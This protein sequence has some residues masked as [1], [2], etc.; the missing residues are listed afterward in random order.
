MQTSQLA[1]PLL[2]RVGFDNTDG[3]QSQGTVALVHTQLA[4]TLAAIVTPR[5][6]S[7]PRLLATAHRLLVTDGVKT[8]TAVEIQRVGKTVPRRAHPLQNRCHVDWNRAAL[9]TT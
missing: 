3:K 2:H 7:C 1:E 6:H 9:V 5:S 4:A 8:Q